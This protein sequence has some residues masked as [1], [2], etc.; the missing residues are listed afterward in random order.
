MWYFITTCRSDSRIHDL[1]I[2]GFE[3]S[4]GLSSLDYRPGSAYTQY[5]IRSN[6]LQTRNFYKEMTAVALVP[7]SLHYSP[8]I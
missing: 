4:I 2:K 1:A 5:I 6:R 3:N 8:I 7:Y